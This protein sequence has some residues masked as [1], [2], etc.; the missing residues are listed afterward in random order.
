[1]STWRIW[2][3]SKF[4]HWTQRL[5]G[6]KPSPIRTRK[7]VV[8]AGS[9]QQA[10]AISTVADLLEGKCS[11]KTIQ[12]GFDKLVAEQTKAFDKENPDYT[13]SVGGPKPT[14]GTKASPKAEPKSAPVKAPKPKKVK[15][16]A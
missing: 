7:L 8:A 14:K 13:F 2:T 4:Q 9:V 11:N 15:A 10:V 5:S 6:K 1:M 16:A 12:A 3:E